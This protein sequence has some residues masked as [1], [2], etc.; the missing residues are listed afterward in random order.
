MVGCNLPHSFKSGSTLSKIHLSQSQK[1]DLVCPAALLILW[2]ESFDGFRHC[3]PTNCSESYV[4]A[5]HQT[6][7]RNGLSLASPFHQEVQRLDRT[8]SAPSMVRKQLGPS[9]KPPFL[10][11]PLASSHRLRHAVTPSWPKRDATSAPSHDATSSRQNGFRL[12]FDLMLVVPCVHMLILCV[13]S[14]QFGVFVFI[15]VHSRMVLFE[16]VHVH[17]VKVSHDWWVPTSCTCPRL[18][19]RCRKGLF[20]QS[21]IWSHS[22]FATGWDSRFKMLKKCFLKLG[23]SKE[24]KSWGKWQKGERMFSG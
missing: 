5:S 12:Q 22:M 20:M 19:S 14:I 6:G 4:A 7:N 16:Y 24:Q 2:E 9:P 23:C 3:Y 10:W 18:H 13:Y 11:L 21:R 17:V 15:Y 1:L 8:L